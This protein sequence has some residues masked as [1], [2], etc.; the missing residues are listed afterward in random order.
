MS[1]TAW[2]SVA[3]LWRTGAEAR[4]RLMAEATSLMLTEAAVAPGMKVLEIGAGTG[5]VAVLLS[6]RVGAGGSVVATDGSTVMLEA[7]A[8]AVSAAGAGN[9]TLKVGDASAAD[10]ADGAFDAGVARQV[11]MFLDLDVALPGIRRVLRAG[12]RFGAVVWGASANNP[13]HHVVIEAARAE[14]GWGDA[15]PEVVQ[16]HSRGDLAMYARALEQAGF[17]EV[18]THVVRGTRRFASVAEAIEKV[19]ESPLHTAPI[20]RVAEGRRASAWERV[21]R[22]F[23]AYERSGGLEVPVE[24]FVLGAGK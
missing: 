14:G 2:G 23:A 13:F 10:F 7:A 15:P 5:D 16:A 18:R 24:W 6:G 11:L 17:R 12:A 4:N 20:A 22:G 8:K 1:D 3:E 19:R 9:V 21:E